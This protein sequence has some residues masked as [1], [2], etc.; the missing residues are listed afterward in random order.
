MNRSLI[1]ATLAASAA[2][3]LVAVGGTHSAPTHSV[4]VGPDR[5]G[6]GVLRLDLAGGDAAATLSFA[7]LMPGQ[8]SQRLVW[9]ATNDPFSTTAATLA[10]TIDQLTDRPGPCDT[11]VSKARAEIDSGIGGCTV[12]GDSAAGTPA[13]GNLSRLVELDVRYAVASDSP[14]SCA[15]TDPARVLLP[16]AGP[17]NLRTL[18]ANGTPMSLRRADGSGEPALPPGAGVCLAVALNWPPGVNSAAPDRDHPLDNAAEGD[19]LRVRV[20]FSLTQAHE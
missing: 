20:V 3:A 9:L 18:A 4:D 12:H 14:A 2:V 15:H 6:A 19:T 11:T 16:T 8:R 13:Q 10:L 7:D 17:G 5:L 1:V